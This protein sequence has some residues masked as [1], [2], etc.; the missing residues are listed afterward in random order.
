MLSQRTRYALKA[1][2]ELGL[3]APGATMSAAAISSRRNIPVK[4]L[5]GILAEL[6]RDGVVDVQRG[7]AGGYRLARATSEI[8]FGAVV[9]LMEGPLALLPCVSVSQYRACDDCKDER[10]CELKRLFREVRDSTAEILDGRT[11]ADALGSVQPKLTYP[12]V[13]RKPPSSP[14]SAPGKAAARKARVR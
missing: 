7:R 10:L 6:K 14:Q 11:L 5:E 2:L 4:F 9:R 1:L 13:K 8:S 3:A 12:A